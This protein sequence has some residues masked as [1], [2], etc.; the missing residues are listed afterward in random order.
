MRVELVER[1]LKRIS[2]DKRNVVATGYG[3]SQSHE[4]A[5]TCSGAVVE[6]LRRET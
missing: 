1:L 2:D 5:A 4:L 3:T 6:V